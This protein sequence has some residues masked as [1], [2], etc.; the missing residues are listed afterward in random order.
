MASR[1]PNWNLRSLLIGLLSGAIISGVGS[2]A[3]FAITNAVQD[4]RLE[5]LTKTVERLST[6]TR[7]NALAIAG[8]TKR[9]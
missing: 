8:L 7:E 2:Y 5:M 9:R 3:A 6:V 4:Q 1:A